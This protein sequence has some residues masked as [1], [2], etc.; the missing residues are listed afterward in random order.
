MISG[1]IL[2]DK[3]DAKK[4]ILEFD[5]S[6]IDFIHLDIMDGKF[7]ENKTWTF[8]EIKK[9]CDL[10]NKKLDTHLMVN[11]PSKY[12]KDYACLNNEYI[13][14]H[15]ECDENIF[16]VVNEIKNYG[17]KVGISIKPDSDVNDLYK[18]L[19]LIDLVLIMGVNPGKSGQL[20]NY[21][22]LNKITLLKEKIN[23]INRNVII[24]VDGGI[25]YDTG[26]LCVE[27]GANMLV[28]ASYLHQD[29]KNNV[30]N[31]KKLF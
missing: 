15:L 25:N 23:K 27:S 10:T 29:I 7:T 17:I 31:L 3:I 14:F 20:F 18:Y 2:S 6:N 8:G 16:D 12:I 22:S 24:S 28:S 19:N 1:S 13:T 5:K 9:L 11:K 26:K 21:E 30:D 4:L